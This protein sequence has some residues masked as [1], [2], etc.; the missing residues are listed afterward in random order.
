M[1]SSISIRIAAAL[2]VAA[3]GAGALAGCGGDSSAS[4]TAADTA[5]AS[6]ATSD[7]STATVTE[8]TGATESASIYRPGS[9]TVINETL[10]ATFAVELSQSPSTG[11]AWKQTGGTAASLIELIDQDISTEGDAPGSPGTI[12][13]A[14]RA[15]AEGSGTLVFEEFP[16]G[17]DT[18]SDTVTFE[19]SVGAP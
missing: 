3:L 7:A 11:Y 18:A 9:G 8:A 13:F 10:G 1:N 16:P 2:G 19:V 14:Y 4:T 12:T 17:K 5:T 15:S 6:T